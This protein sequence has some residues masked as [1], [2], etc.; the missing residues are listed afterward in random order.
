MRP[1]AHETA[2]ALLPAV[3]RRTERTD[4]LL[5]GLAGPPGVGKS[6]L[7]HA[8]ADAHGAAVVVGMDGFHLPQAELVR[9]RIDHVKGA[10]ETFDA[11]GFVALLRRLRDFTATVT[12]PVFDRVMEEPVADAVTVAPP[13]RL[14]VVEGNYLLLDGP[15][16][17][18]RGLLDVVWH[19]RLP[20]DVRIRGL[21][22]RH[23]SH[24]R[25]AEAAD[26]WVQ[27]NDEAN[28]KLVASVADRAH[29]IVDLTTARLVPATSA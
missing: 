6:A 15:W 12:A 5:L 24:G 21:V 19:L 29:A 7:A 13:H 16:R 23:M 10:P 18:V 14:V 9:R 20:D 17:P 2:E 11:D 26:E 22:D 3:R 8:I 27:R 28:A 25:S 4:R 1:S